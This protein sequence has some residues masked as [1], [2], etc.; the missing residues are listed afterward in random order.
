[1]G[2]SEPSV[3]IPFLVSLFNSGKLGILN[4]IV[5]TYKPE[6]MKQAVIDA[7]K[8]ESIKR[9]RSMNLSDHHINLG[10][11]IKPVIEWS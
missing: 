4:T 2:N 5:Q 3:T 1:M 8:G 7:E 6:D 10:I 9:Q 11:V